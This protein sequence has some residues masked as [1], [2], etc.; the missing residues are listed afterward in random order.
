MTGPATPLVDGGRTGVFAWQPP[1]GLVAALS[2][3]LDRGRV[4]A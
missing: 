2:D 4:A 3:L 1:A